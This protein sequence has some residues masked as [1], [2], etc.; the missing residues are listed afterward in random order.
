MTDSK[1]IQPQYHL[2]DNDITTLSPQ[3]VNK[4][5]EKKTKKTHRKPK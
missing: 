2:I 4:L 3:T 5:N 1:Q